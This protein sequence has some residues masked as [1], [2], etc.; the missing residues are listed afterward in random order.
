MDNILIFRLFVQY[1]PTSED[2]FVNF[3][4]NNQ[5]VAYI[6][7]YYPTRGSPVAIMIQFRAQDQHLRNLFSALVGNSTQ[8]IQVTNT[9]H[10]QYT[11]TPHFQ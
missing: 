4:K 7:P 1:C 2:I 8:S 3:P 5:Y 6:H 10:N 9:K 11:T